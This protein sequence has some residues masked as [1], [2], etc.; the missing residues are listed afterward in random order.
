LQRW[1]KK[2]H[3]YASQRWLCL[4]TK[5]SSTK[6]NS[7]LTDSNFN[8]LVTNPTSSSVDMQWLTSR[9]STLPNLDELSNICQWDRVV[10]I[11]C[12]SVFFCVYNWSWH[13]VTTL[14]R[15]SL[16]SSTIPLLLALVL[17]AECLSMPHWK[18]LFTASLHKLS[19]L[20]PQWK[21]LVFAFLFVN[22]GSGGLS[23]WT[24][25]PCI[26]GSSW[27]IHTINLSWGFLLKI[28]F[29]MLELIRQI[30]NI[31]KFHVAQT[32]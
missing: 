28:N 4:D 1:T 12:N 21:T 17:K 22:F 6:S 10:I 11:G 31:P 2:S 13:W 27:Q 18:A 15:Q 30:L 7:I 24:C 26:D 8:Y 19:Q 14:V 29:Q 9:N 16:F 23:N 25:F 32:C 20:L 3:K 5:F